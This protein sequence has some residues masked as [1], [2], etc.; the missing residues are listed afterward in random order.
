[1]SCKKII[2]AISF[3]TIFGFLFSFNIPAAKAMTAG[4]IQTLI[5]QLLSQIAQLQKQLAEIQGVPA[6]WCHG[7]NTNLRYGDSGPEV[8]ALL[9]ALEKEGLYSKKDSSSD[10]NEQVASAVTGFQE[11][12]R[13]EILTPLGLK[14]GT[15][16][17]GKS[18]R[19]MLNNLYGC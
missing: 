17:V 19:G 6:A 16:F 9:I 2:F 5:Q 8:E 7:F 1:M 15:G 18:T 10:F 12:Y 11:R 4:E 13:G 3:L 14:Y